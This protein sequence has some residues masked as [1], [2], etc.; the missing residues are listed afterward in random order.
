[1]TKAKIIAQVIAREAGF[2]DR[3]DD[4]GGKTKYGITEK[5]A[6]KWGYEGQMHDLPYDTAMKIYEDLYWPKALDDILALSV[7]IAAELF[8]T[9]VNMGVGTAGK[10]LQRSLNVLN[11]LETLFD[12]VK[13][14]GIVGP[15]T[16][17]ALEAYLDKRRGR[18]ETALLT[19]LNCLQ[20]ARYVEL[21]ER[22]KSDEANLFGWLCHRIQL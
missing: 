2:S 14:D 18:G 17:K 5:V 16:V 9:G 13:V 20:G 6:R 21:T 19:A 11:K 1:M 3:K 8:D 7:P 22:R 10:F 15:A 12:D 4:A